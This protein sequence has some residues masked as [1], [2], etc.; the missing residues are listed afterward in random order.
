MTNNLK[1]K[2]SLA[3]GLVSA[4]VVLAPI[5]GYAADFGVANKA[6]SYS[7]LD[8]STEAGASTLLNRLT[9]AADA[10]CP[11][12]STTFALHRLYKTCVDATLGKAVRN[13]NRTT[14]SKLYTERTGFTVTTQLSMNSR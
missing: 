6:V 10:V 7:D 3:S 8:L 11:M 4:I 13:V 12:D 9:L 1:L 14:L 5:Y 2:F